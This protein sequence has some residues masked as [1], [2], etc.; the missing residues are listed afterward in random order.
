[1]GE[2]KHMTIFAEMSIN[3]QKINKYLTDVKN[4]LIIGML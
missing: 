4:R 2:R 1:M 3:W